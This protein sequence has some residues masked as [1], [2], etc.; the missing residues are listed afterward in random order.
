VSPSPAAPPTTDLRAFFERHWSVIVST[1]PAAVRDGLRA[2]R[3]YA[4]R[5]LRRSAYRSLVEVGCADGS[6]LLD[7]A[8]D[9]GL[10]YVGLDLA[11]GAVAATRARLAGAG[12]TALRADVCDLP[13]LAVQP[14]SPALI[15]FPFNVFGNLPDPQRALSAVA[16]VGADILLLT[17]DT[18]TAAGAVRG[19]Y[20]AACGLAGALTRDQAGVHF[21]A[22][23]FRSSVYHP[24][25]LSG[26]LHRHGFQVAVGRYGAVGLAYHGWCGPRSARTF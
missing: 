12:G 17:Y 13:D 7:T 3:A 8:I 16:A 14:Q 18:G 24:P 6:L 26:W 5:L 2:E 25:V 22:G 9:H 10:G 15:A 20:Y 21:V 1:R 11:E 23:D 19:E 4:D